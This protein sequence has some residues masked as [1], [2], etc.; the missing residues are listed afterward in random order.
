MQQPN[1]SDPS[2]WYV[3]ATFEGAEQRVFSR[4]AL[5][6]LTLFWPRF[7]INDTVEPL[8]PAYLFH[9]AGS[10]EAALGPLGTPG[11]INVL[12]ND[13]HPAPVL[14]GAIEHLIGLADEESV[15]DPGQINPAFRLP[16]VA[17]WKPLDRVV[18]TEGPFAGFRGHI[19]DGIVRR[20]RTKIILACPLGDVDVQIPSEWISLDDGVTPERIAAPCHHRRNRRRKRQDREQ[21]QQAL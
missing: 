11:V 7:R 21:D 20:N 18:V 4:L 16:C 15:I 5:Q 10:P 19:S 6:G 9:R 8:F 12:G 2:R 1:T 14:R 17:G 3:V 13:N